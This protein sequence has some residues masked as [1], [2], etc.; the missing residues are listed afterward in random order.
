VLRSCPSSIFRISFQISRASRFSPSPARRLLRERDELRRV[1]GSDALRILREGVANRRFL[2]VLGHLV[3]RQGQFLAVE[4]FEDP[5][6]LRL[7]LQSQ[8]LIFGAVLHPDLVR[9]GEHGGRHERQK[10]DHAH[11]NSGGNFSLGGNLRKSVPIGT[12]E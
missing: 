4:I 12:S 9:N 11:G 3:L 6:G 10:R 8:V 2:R 7:A 1:L 5:L